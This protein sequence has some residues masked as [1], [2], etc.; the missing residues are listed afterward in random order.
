MTF[1][2][3]RRS[4]DQNFL[5]GFCFSRRGRRFNQGLFRHKI[6]QGLVRED[7]MENNALVSGEGLV[8]VSALVVVLDPAL[9][10]DI[11]EVEVG[12]VEQKN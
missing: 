10:Q 11:F 6:F 3:T 1:S 12:D 9:R 7:Q 8:T 5:G 4:F 2:G